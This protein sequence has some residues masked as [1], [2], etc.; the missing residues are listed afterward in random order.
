[1]ILLAH[2]IIVLWGQ[3]HYVTMHARLPVTDGGEQMLFL[4]NMWQ[5]FML[6][7]MLT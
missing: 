4:W 1:M 6:W 2:I 5:R 7:P 3:Y